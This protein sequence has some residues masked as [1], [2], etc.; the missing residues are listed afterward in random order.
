MKIAGAE[1]ADELRSADEEREARRMRAM[2]GD[3]E[4]VE[5]AH[6]QELVPIPRRSRQREHAAERGDERRG[7]NRA[8]LPSR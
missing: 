5:R 7:D 4:V 1:H 3:I 8:P 6:E 2:A